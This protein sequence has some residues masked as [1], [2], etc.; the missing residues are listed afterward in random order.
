MTEIATELMVDSIKED[1]VRYSRAGFLNKRACPLILTC[2]FI[3]KL[4]ICKKDDVY[5]VIMTV[6][7]RMQR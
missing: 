7:L 1:L 3:A 4:L 5:Y 6:F 2:V